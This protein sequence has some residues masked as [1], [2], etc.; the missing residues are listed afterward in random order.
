LQTKGSP[1]KEED[2]VKRAICALVAVCAVALASTAYAAHP[3]VGDYVVAPGQT[4]TFSNMTLNSC[5]TDTVGVYIL[6]TGATTQSV[7]FGSNSGSECA[8]VSLASQSFT[9]NTTADQRFRVWLQDIEC[10]VTYDPLGNHAKVTAR[11]ASLND[12]G[13]NDAGPDCTKATSP[14]IPKGQ[15]VNFIATVSVG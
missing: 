13:I 1:D 4:I 14:N 5:N 12:A 7:V 2:P 8:V 3:E 15:N 11:Y 6:Q 9:N 10:G